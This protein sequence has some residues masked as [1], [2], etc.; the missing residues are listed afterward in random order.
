MEEQSQLNLNKYL[1]SL[2]EAERDKYQS[3]SADYFHKL[4][5]PMLV[6]VMGRLK[7]AI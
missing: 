2:S 5:I 4:H 6:R 1:N 7:M 3:F